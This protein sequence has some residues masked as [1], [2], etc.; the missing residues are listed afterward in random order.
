MAARVRVRRHLHGSQRIL[1]DRSPNLI[2]G[3][4]REEMTVS[5]EVLWLIL[6]LH[7]KGVRNQGTAGRPERRRRA[8]LR[9]HRSFFTR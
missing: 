4:P 6:A 1:N 2:S 9:D 7:P 5:C 8:A 3:A